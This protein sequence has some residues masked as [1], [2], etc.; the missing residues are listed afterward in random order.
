MAMETYCC[1]ILK[2]NKVPL[3]PYVAPTLS[4]SFIALLLYIGA[5]L[6]AIPLL[7]LASVV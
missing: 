4:S 7:K 6:A 3:K 5:K 1:S 2:H